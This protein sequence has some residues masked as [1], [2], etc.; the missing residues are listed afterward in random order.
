MGARRR[1]RF[2]IIRP[3]QCITITQN[4][5]RIRTHTPHNPHTALAG[6]SLLP[7]PLPRSPPLQPHSR[8]SRIVS[9]LPPLPP[10]LCPCP[11]CPRCRMAQNLGLTQS[12]SLSHSR[13]VQTRPCP[14]RPLPRPLTH[15]RTSSSTTC[16]SLPCG[17]R[18]HL[19]PPTTLMAWLPGAR[20]SKSWP[21]SS[22]ASP[23]S[24]WK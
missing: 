20:P 1:E 5:L 16:P 6:K 18:P 24:I 19:L 17:T 10:P 15:P 4:T 14:R 21:P 22:M 7:A 3:F 12:I 9:P 11:L 2:V 23:T 13:H 8:W